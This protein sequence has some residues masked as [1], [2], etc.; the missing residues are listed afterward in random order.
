MPIIHIESFI[1]IQQMLTCLFYSDE[2]LLEKKMGNNLI[3]YFYVLHFYE[4]DIS[5]KF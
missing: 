2:D 3:S 5:I 1:L 4:L